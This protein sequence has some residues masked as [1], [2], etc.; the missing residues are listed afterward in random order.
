MTKAKDDLEAVRAI[1]AALEGFEAVDQERIIRW[2]REKLGLSTRKE[3]TQHPNLS[4]PPAQATGGTVQESEAQPHPDIR[5][6]V[7][8]KNPRTDSQF[9][10]TV[11]YYYQ[12]V[13]P[14]REKKNAITSSDLQDACRKVNRERFSNPIRTLFNT[15]KGGLLDKGSER[16]TFALN[17][18]GEN[19]VAMALPGGDAVKETRLRRKKAK[20]ARPKRARAARRAE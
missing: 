17:S 6:F 16:G 14:E 7:N 8:T 9:A 3:D 13:A 1:T 19:L 12:F 18:V 5:T 4:I 10:A 20:L 2:A 11:A 15:L